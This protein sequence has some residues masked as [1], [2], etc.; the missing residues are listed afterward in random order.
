MQLRGNATGMRVMME[1]QLDK[2]VLDGHLPLHIQKTA[3]R[4]IGHSDKTAHDF[5]ILNDAWNDACKVNGFHLPSSPP[6]NNANPTS[7][8]SPIHS[9]TFMSIK[10][11]EETREII[12]G[13]F[14][15][16]THLP[17]LK[18]APLIPY[19]KAWGSNHP[20]IRKPGLQR[21]VFTPMETYIIGKLYRE[22]MEDDSNPNNFCGP[23]VTGKTSVHYRILKAIR[24]NKKMWPDFHPRHV[25]DSARL[26]PGLLKVSYSPFTLPLSLFILFFIFHFFIFSPRL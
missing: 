5:Y 26:R 1:T 10:V 9:Y 14:D 4:M 24:S 19:D 8:H 7:T 2:A 22:M 20:A 18:P 6:S 17:S 13:D 11:M 21:A 16:L 25:I 12:A 15:D 23:V 3:H